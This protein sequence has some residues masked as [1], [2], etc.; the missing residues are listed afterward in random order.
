VSHRATPSRLPPIAAI[1]LLA[2]FPRVARAQTVDGVA[3]EPRPTLFQWSYGTSFGGGPPGRDEP[4]V[5]DR[6]DFTESTAT[7]G[8]GVV[9]LETGYTYFFDEEHGEKTAG[10]SFPEPLLRVGLLA[11]WLEFRIGWNYAEKKGIGPGGST[12]ETGS[13]DLYLGLK[14]AMTPQEGILPEMALIPQMTVPVGDP[15]FTAG[16]VL[17]GLNWVYGWEIGDC[18]SLAGSTQGNGAVDDVTGR[19]YLEMGQ[20]MVIGYSLLDRLGAFTEWFA[21]FPH[22]AD[23]AKPEHY[24]DG[25]FTF[26]VT[27]DLQLDVRAGLGLNDAAGDYFVGAGSIVRF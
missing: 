18:I 24:F 10:H 3:R 11:E 19:R 25:G 1:L 9:Q 17:P 6:P 4:L 22:S 15:P 7:V 12:V 21:F 20:S 26:S 14:L 13:E 8:R 23:T 27:D 2:V 5:G 16:E